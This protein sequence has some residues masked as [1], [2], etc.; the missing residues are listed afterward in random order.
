MSPCLSRVQTCATVW[1]SHI[2]D[3]E[4]CWSI[5][6]WQKS[7]G[8]QAEH[9]WGEKHRSETCL[10]ASFRV[11]SLRWMLLVGLRSPRINCHF[12][13]RHTKIR[14]KML[15]KSSPNLLKS[16][17]KL[18][19]PIRFPNGPRTAQIVPTY[20]KNSLK[21]AAKYTQVYVNAQ[22][23]MYKYTLRM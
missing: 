17:P 3:V 15:L 11:Y 10:N 22:C 4:T 2:H 18:W 16:F 8:T 1:Y 7:L 20:S 5:P 19:C 12:S 13:L 21:I 9:Q 6:P 23:T 14:S